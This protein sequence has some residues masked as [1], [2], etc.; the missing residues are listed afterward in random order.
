MDEHPSVAAHDTRPRWTRLAALGLFLAGLGP[1]LLV[2]TS[3]GWSLDVSTNAPSFGV[4]AAV[5]WL[6]AF[7]V[8]RYGRWAKWV[9]I[10][11]AVL[12]LGAMLWTAFSISAVGSFFDFVPAVLIVPGAIL[13]I[14]CCIASLVA[15]RRGHVTAAAE[16]GERAGMRIAVGV[17]A[18]AV[19]LSGILTLTSHSSTDAATSQARSSMKNFKFVPTSYSVAGGSR[20]F[21]QNEDPFRHTFTVTGLG[22]DIEFGPGTSKLVTIPSTPGT[23]ILYCRYHTGNPDK[24]TKGDMAAT[25][26]VT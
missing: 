9:G 3:I 8:W 26:V 18:V 5:P 22:I 24:P 4:I 23:Y 1:L 25:L 7:L 6:G 11:V 16:G 12:L 2:I 21:V 17:V 15:N 14:A 20:V 19:V 13:A 10:V